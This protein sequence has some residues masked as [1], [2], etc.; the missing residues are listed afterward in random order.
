MALRNY[1]LTLLIKL[2]LYEVA[3]SV[4]VFLSFFPH[5]HF[6][7]FALAN[8]LFQSP[9]MATAFGVSGLSLCVGLSALLFRFYITC[10]IHYIHGIPL[11]ILVLP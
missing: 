10:T 4:S 8:L 3:S 9:V 7:S 11:L 2:F 6:F 1:A 5:F